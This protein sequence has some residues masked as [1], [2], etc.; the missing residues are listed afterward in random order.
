MVYIYAYDDIEM[1][2]KCVLASASHGKKDEILCEDE[3]C[4]ILL[5][6]SGKKG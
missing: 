5:F 6:P 2:K 1:K 4:C 3:K